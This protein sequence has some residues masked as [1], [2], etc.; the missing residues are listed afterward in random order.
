[1]GAADAGIVNAQTI[2]IV[3]MVVITV[4]APRVV[5]FLFCNIVT[6]A[7]GHTRRMRRRRMRRRR[8]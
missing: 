3:A 5:L 8:K 4:A 2:T 7:R 1:M 6:C